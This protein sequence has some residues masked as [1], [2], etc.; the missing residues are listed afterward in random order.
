MSSVS[1][2]TNGATVYLENNIP[3]LDIPSYTNVQIEEYLRN[4]ENGDSEI[5]AMWQRFTEKWE[6][7]EEDVT[8]SLEFIAWLHSKADRLINLREILLLRA[9]ASFE[10]YL[11]SVTEDVTDVSDKFDVDFKAVSFVNKIIYGIARDHNAKD[12]DAMREYNERMASQT[13]TVANCV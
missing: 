12:A 7:D 3:P 9:M 4:M 5:F 6:S 1:S 2:T 10:T 11:A 13:D 8:Q